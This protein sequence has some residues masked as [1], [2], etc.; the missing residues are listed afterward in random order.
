MQG[1][2]AVTQVTD[3]AAPAGA[4]PAG[5]D[6]VA[7]AAR[8]LAYEKRII[9]QIKANNPVASLETESLSLDD[10]FKHLIRG[11]KASARVEGQ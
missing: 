6:A 10:I 1:L 11:R 7:L 9:E 2:D 8:L 4:D 5:R 3:P